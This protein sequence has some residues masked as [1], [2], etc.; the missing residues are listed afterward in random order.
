M[1]RLSEA[2]NKALETDEWKK[3]CDQT[4]TCASRKFTPAEAQTYVSAFQDTV[5]GYLK[6]LK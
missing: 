4:Y 1:K 5:K 3:F 2:V 6:N